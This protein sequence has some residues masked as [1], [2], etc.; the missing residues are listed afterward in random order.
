MLYSQV[1]PVPNPVFIFVYIYLPIWL[2]TWT[3]HLPSYLALDFDMLRVHSGAVSFEV[4]LR[5][6]LY[7]SILGDT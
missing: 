4:A 7:A 6:S 3:L 1:L 5:S 2:W